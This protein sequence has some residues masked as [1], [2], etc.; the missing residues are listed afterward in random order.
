MVVGDKPGDADVNY[1]VAPDERCLKIAFFDHSYE[2]PHPDLP[3]LPPPVAPSLASP[4]DLPL[5]AER[6][7]SRVASLPLG[8]LPASSPVGSSPTG[9]P[10]GLGLVAEVGGTTRV[11]A[12][13][14]GAARIAGG[15]V[16]GGVV[17]G[18]VGG[19]VGVGVGGGGG[20]NGGGGGGGGGGV[21]G[22]S[23]WATPARF[24][25][26]PGSQ[27]GGEMLVSSSVGSSIGS[28]IGSS[29]GTG[30]GSGSGSGGGGGGGDV[31]GLAAEEEVTHAQGTTT[32][33]GVESVAAENMLRA[34]GESFDIVAC[35]GHPMGIVTDFVRYFVAAQLDDANNVDT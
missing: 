13:A 12:D 1:G 28:S 22:G 19:V 10:I 5:E 25:G 16:D 29:V 32:G 18:G 34:Y 24:T 27:G 30:G 11:A 9:P 4:V 6:L 23:F 20:G 7:A 2:H 35:G 21:A 26:R 31:K 3:P 33:T 8:A 17:D 15:V 14:G